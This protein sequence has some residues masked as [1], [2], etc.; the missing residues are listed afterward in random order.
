EL[1]F[2]ADENGKIAFTKNKHNLRKEIRNAMFQR[3][4]AIDREDITLLATL[5]SAA[6]WGEEKWNVALDEYF[7]EYEYVGTDSAARSEK[8]FQIL[9]DPSLADLI[10]AGMSAD[11]AAE[12]L[13]QHFPGR[14]WLTIQVID[15]GEDDLAWA[16]WSLI[17]LDRSDEED[18]LAIELI[19]FGQR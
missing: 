1:A 15:D 18:H 17:D 3:V 4:E 13:E 2:G 8:F 16:L 7:E 5:D 6:G 19:R 12:L 10:A 11:R 9:E 14:L